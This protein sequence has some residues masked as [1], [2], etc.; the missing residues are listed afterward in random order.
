MKYFL[1]TAK[2]SGICWAFVFKNVWRHELGRFLGVDESCN[3]SR[4]IFKLF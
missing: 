4:F 1:E 3:L 2:R